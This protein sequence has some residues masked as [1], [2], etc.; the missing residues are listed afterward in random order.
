MTLPR[1]LYAICFSFWLVMMSL[2]VR[3]E[4]FQIEG[5]GRKVPLDFLFRLML[6]QGQT[7]NLQIYQD[8]S[9]IG[10]LEVGPALRAGIP[11]HQ[12][13]VRI[14]ANTLVRLGQE[15]PFR[16][17]SEIEFFLNKETL[18]VERILGWSRVRK[19][20]E[21]ARFE[22]DFATRIVTFT[23]GGHDSLESWTGSF[24]EASD[25]IMTEL[26]ATPAMQ[27]VA[28]AAVERFAAQP[29]L[30]ELPRALITTIQVR[31]ESVETYRILINR[32]GLRSD[33][34]INLV[35]QI[36]LVRTPFGFEL[37]T[38]EDVEA[39]SL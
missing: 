13:A 8:G 26:G 21:T 7:S 17:V 12:Y 37:S 24:Q 38:D 29:E 25:E 6:D 30:E 9:V 31:D 22:V 18:A 19:I 14:F 23:L 3:Q 16:F 2:L 28:R 5:A 32:E 15:E 33:I 39:P 4:V 10:S 36:L 35:G 27:L 20:S 1:L 34:F 11:E